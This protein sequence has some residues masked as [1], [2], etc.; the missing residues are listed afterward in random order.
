MSIHAELNDF[1]SVG[2]QESAA[3][4]ECMRAAKGLG[5]TDGDTGLGAE[6]NGCVGRVRRGPRGVCRDWAPEEQAPGRL[7]SAQPVLRRPLDTPPSETGGV[8]KNFRKGSRAGDA[9][10]SSD[11]PIHHPAFLDQFNVDRAI[12]ERNNDAHPPGAGGFAAGSGICGEDSVCVERFGRTSSSPSP[13]A[14]TPSSTRSSSRR[15]CSTSW[16]GAS[17]RIPS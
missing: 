13:S 4:G 8:R 6:R 2:M 14:G 17:P 15:S 5:R 3:R 7:G 16:R 9:A 11:L 12:Y 10:D 1:V